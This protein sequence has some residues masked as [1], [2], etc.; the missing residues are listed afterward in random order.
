MLVCGP[1]RGV[2]VLGCCP[3]ASSHPCLSCRSMP[4]CATMGSSSLLRGG[5]HALQRLL[6]GTI[7]VLCMSAASQA[8]AASR[9]E[10]ALPRYAT[11]KGRAVGDMSD[12]D[13]HGWMSIGGLA[14]P[15]QRGGGHSGGGDGGYTPAPLLASPISAS[16]TPL[17]DDE[18][19][20]TP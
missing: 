12:H 11:L 2:A 19:R 3:S 18:V 7:L 14:T 4:S 20:S 15:L 6:S 13:S 5:K 1:G 10:A 9:G 8:A 17:R 16:N